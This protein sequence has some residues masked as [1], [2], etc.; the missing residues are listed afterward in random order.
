M[1]KLN[2][3]F[4]TGISELDC[5]VTMKKFLNGILE[6]ESNL[7]ENKNATQSVVSEKYRHMI[8]NVAEGE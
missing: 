6:Y 2:K 7:S 1:V 8:E 4:E 5:D 3:A